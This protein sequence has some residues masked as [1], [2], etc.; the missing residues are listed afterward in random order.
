[1]NEQRQYSEDPNIQ[2]ALELLKPDPTYQPSIMQKY[3]AEFWSMSAG[4]TMASLRNCYYRRPFFAGLQLHAMFV[5]GGYIFSQYAK[6]FIH[7]LEAR[8]DTRLRNYI[9]LHPE[10][11]PEPVRVKYGD[12]LEPWTPIR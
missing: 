5:A 8:R 7:F 12:I 4:F 10:L 3:S 9:I 11:F 1:M 6:K 2:W